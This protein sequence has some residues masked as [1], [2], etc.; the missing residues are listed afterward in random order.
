MIPL[1]SDQLISNN[2][3]GSIVFSKSVKSHPLEIF[4]IILIFGTIFGITGLIVAIPLYTIIKVILRSIY[5]E[6]KVISDFLK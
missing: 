6:N 2:P 1:S 4:I 3:V 5:A